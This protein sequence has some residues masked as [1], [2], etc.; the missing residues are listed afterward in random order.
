MVLVVVLFQRLHEAGVLTDGQVLAQRFP[1][2]EILDGVTLQVE[3]EAVPDVHQ[4][5]GKGWLQQGVVD[6][7]QK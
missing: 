3:D 5:S 4:E 7:R 6:A 1:R 2:A